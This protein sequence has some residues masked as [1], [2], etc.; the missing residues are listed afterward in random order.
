MAFRLYDSA[1]VELEGQ[2]APVQV[3]KDRKNPAAF[4]VGEYQYDVDGR[5]LK[6]MIDAP[7]IVRLHSLQSARDAGLSTQYRREVD[8]A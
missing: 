7:V 5:P 4:N 8:P 1:W 2:G 6:S 3:F